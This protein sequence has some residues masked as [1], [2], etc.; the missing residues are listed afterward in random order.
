MSKR[1]KIKKL[2]SKVCEL[3]H[4]LSLARAEIKRLNLKLDV[5]NGEE[6]AEV[7]F[8]ELQSTS[9]IKKVDITDKHICY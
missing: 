2:K 8:F 1:N 3:K 4:Q 9:P 6:K 5:D 7:H